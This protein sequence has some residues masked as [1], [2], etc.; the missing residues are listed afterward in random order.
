[1][2][3]RAIRVK[4][5]VENKTRRNKM[6]I[7]RQFSGLLAKKFLRGYQNCNIHVQGSIFRLHLFFP[8]SSIF[9]N[10]PG[11]ECKLF[12][13]PTAFFRQVFSKLFLRV[14]R[15]ILRKIPFW[16]RFCLYTKNFGTL[17]E[18]VPTFSQKFWARLFNLHSACPEENFEDFFIRKSLKKMENGREKFGLS[19]NDM[20]MF[21]KTQSVLPEEVFT[22]ESVFL[23][24][25]LLLKFFRALL[26]KF[27]FL[28][29]KCRQLVRTPNCF[30]WEK[31]FESFL[32]RF[33]FF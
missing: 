30:L 21:V 18:K 20:L 13:L 17:I 33:F 10:V 11:S 5:L 25:F 27:D 8:E 32:K 23:R 3:R 6:E 14:Q 15:T 26:L 22:H 7:E 19:V 9:C 1:M 31:H 29:A 2:S 12:R 16:R 28:R 24:L 4:V